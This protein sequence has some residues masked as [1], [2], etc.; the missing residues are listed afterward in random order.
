[1]GHLIIYSRYEYRVLSEEHFT[2]ASENGAT[3]WKIQIHYSC[4][5]REMVLAF[6]LIFAK[7]VMHA[8]IR[9]IPSMKND[10]LISYRF[11]N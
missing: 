7:H 1:M 9:K 2:P 6:G 11:L 8:N 4:T 10:L 3:E 5:T